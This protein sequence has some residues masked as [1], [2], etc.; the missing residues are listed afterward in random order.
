MLQITSVNQF[1]ARL[2]K[3]LTLKIKSDKTNHIKIVDT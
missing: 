1:V 3:M 2:S